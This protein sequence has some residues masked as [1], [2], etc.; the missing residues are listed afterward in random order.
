[1]RRFSTPL[2]A[3]TDKGLYCEAGGFYID[4]HRVVDVAVVTHA[5]S[6]HARRGSKHYITVDS[7]VGLLRARIGKKISV[8]ARKYGERFR[9]GETTVSLHSAGHILGSAQVR[10]EC[11]G[12][13]WVASGD[14]KRDPDPS[15]DPFESVRCDT[16]ITE[17]TFGTPKYTWKKGARHGED[18][19]RWWVENAAAGRNAIVFG[20]SLGKG[21][22]ILAELASA[23]EAG[24]TPEGDR[25]VLIHSAMEEL[26][27][28]YRAEGRRLA[29]T[30]PLDAAIADAAA[31]DTVLRGELILA[32]PSVLGESWARRLGDY[33]TAFASG[34]MQTGGWGRGKYDH[35]FVMSDHADWNDINQTIR[36][37][38]ASRIFVQHRDGALVRHLRALGLE[39]YSADELVAER[40]ARLPLRTLDLFSSL[41]A[42]D[43]EMP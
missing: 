28:C 11:A 6:D 3:W 15:C 9:L 1:M 39:A 14:Y 18:L 23:R 26:T 32:P 40:F 12:E 13:V 30:R 38:G 34:W 8:E 31:S 7:G 22:R 43:A 25:P 41:G 20:Y 29:P 35:G 21:Q 17:A 37:S 2:I 36:E 27:E 4:P 5:H 42:P 16:F 24:L 33:R 10:V 19:A